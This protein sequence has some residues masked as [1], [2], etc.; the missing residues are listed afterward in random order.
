MM[1]PS[2]SYRLG[3]WTRLA[4][5]VAWIVCP[6]TLSAQQL[7][8]GDSRALPLP[9]LVRPVVRLAVEVPLEP[10]P[11]Q[12]VERSGDPVVVRAEPWSLSDRVKPEKIEPLPAIEPAYQIGLRFGSKQPAAPDRPWLDIRPRTLPPDGAEILSDQQLPDDRSGLEP[13]DALPTAVQLYAV[14]LQ[15]QDIWRGASFG[16]Q[17]LYFEDRLLERYGSIGCVLKYCPLVHCGAHFAFASATLPISVLHSPPY[18]LVR[19]GHPS[20]FEAVPVAEQSIRDVAAAVMR[21]RR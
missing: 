19:N 16:Y 4:S 17:P 5:V 18:R 20:R 10:L 21:K 8:D 7:D 12:A 6:A 1:I 14:D 9:R 15:S 11:R 13:A 3:L 2:N